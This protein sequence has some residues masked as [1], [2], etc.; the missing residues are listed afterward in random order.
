MQFK[1]LFFGGLATCLT[2]LSFMAKADKAAALILREGAS[3]K[4]SQALATQYPSAGKLLID[5]GGLRLCS[6]TL[7]APQWVLTAAHCLKPGGAVP[8]VTSGNFSIG[9]AKYNVESTK[10]N[11]GFV[12]NK[13]NLFS[14]YDTGLVKLTAPVQGVTPAKLSSNPKITNK[15]GV[16]VGFG[17]NGSIATGEVD[18]T[19]G[20]KR[21]G[22]NT[23]DGLGS[24]FNRFWSDRVAIADFDAPDGSVN[25]LGEPAAAAL[26]YLPAQSDS[27]GGFYM[28]GQLV[29]VH[30]S[31]ART[32]SG[33]RIPPSY[34][35]VFGLT[36]IQPNLDWISSTIGGGV[37]LTEDVLSSDPGAET[38]RVEGDSGSITNAQLAF[39]NSSGRTSTPEQS[40]LFA[41]LFIGSIFGLLHRQKIE[42]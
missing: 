39:A 38:P 42:Q 23:I 4:D 5:G 11:P 41:V 25:S 27:G 21:A 15:S 7:I 24:K 33:E 8:D 17:R 20:I 22:V 35:K 30:S 6:G 31:G 26:E 2:T 40:G 16:F 10:I 34:G 29:S 9:D 3:E 14:G 28:D 32:A 12:E 1:Y 13:Y 18:G 19:E 36:R 37:K